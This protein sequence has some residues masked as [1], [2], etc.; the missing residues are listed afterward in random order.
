MQPPFDAAPPP[1]PPPSPPG[2]GPAPD[3]PRIFCFACGSSIDARAEICPHCGVRQR[4]ASP[5]AAAPGAPSKVAA[6]LLAILL[7][8]FGAHRFYLGQYWTGLLYALFSWTGVPAVVGLIEGILILAKP[9]EQWAR[10]HPEPRGGVTGLALGCLLVAAVG[11][12]LTIA[13]I[14][15]LVFLGSSLGP[16]DPGD[17][18]RSLLAARG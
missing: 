11:A 7:G 9:D 6:G 14:V 18:L 13:L 3:V 5:T 4:V 15:F 1:P 16:T 10:E 12:A 17:A 8:W 2:S